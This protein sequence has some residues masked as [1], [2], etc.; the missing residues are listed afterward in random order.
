MVDCDLSADSFCHVLNGIK[1]C[2]SLRKV[3]LTRNR[4]GSVRVAESIS[5]ALQLSH[6]QSI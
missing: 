4:I 5:S 6:L 3:N 1:L 2:K